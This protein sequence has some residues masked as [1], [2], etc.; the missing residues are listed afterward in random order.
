[1]TRPSI[2]LPQILRS[3]ARAV[4]L[5]GLA[6]TLGAAGCGDRAEGTRA[7]RAPVADAEPDDDGLPAEPAPPSVDPCQLLTDEEISEQ[8]WLT[9]SPSQ[10]EHYNAKGFDITKTEVPWGVSRRCEYTFRSK[11]T[12]SGGPVTRGDF[13]ILVS[14]ASLGEVADR[15]KKPIPGVG[16]EA[17]RHQQVWYVRAGDLIA[18][19]TDF[20]GTSEPGLEPDAG[21]IA[22][23]KRMAERLK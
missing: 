11:A 12:V 9:I 23:L 3:A 6:L 10:R 20:D 22:L 19:L 4:A 7:D 21:R 16:D 17:Y 2:P 8:L 15:E 5:A 1:M 14:R 13:N 18:S